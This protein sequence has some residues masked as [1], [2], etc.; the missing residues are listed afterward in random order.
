MNSHS[1]LQKSTH[2]SSAYLTASIQPRPFSDPNY[3]QSQPM[4]YDFSHVDLFTHAPVRS[5][6]QRK[7]MIEQPRNKY[8]QETDRVAPQVVQQIDAPTTVGQSIQRQDSPEEELQMKPLPTTMIPDNLRTGTQLSQ[9]PSNFIQPMRIQ[10]VGNTWREFDNNH[11]VPNATQQA[12]IAVWEN[13]NRKNNSTVI[14]KQSF[15]DAVQNN[16]QQLKNDTQQGKLT[17]IV[18]PQ[19]DVKIVRT[20]PNPSKK[21]RPYQVDDSQSVK[22]KASIDRR[23]PRFVFIF[24]LD[25]THISFNAMDNLSGFPAL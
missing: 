3:D 5:P 8:E 21:Q 25:E 2:E 15:I 13:R 12:A 6:V 22:I 11:I 18:V 14:K 1:R 4:G 7:P 9:V 16:A 24:H 17:E 19:G 10:G 23:N 20:I